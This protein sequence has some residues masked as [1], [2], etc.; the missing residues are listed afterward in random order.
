MEFE[1]ALLYEKRPF[2]FTA[3]FLLLIMAMAHAQSLPEDRK[4]QVKL[5]RDDM[6]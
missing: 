3:L 5:A 4:M 2:L 6:R 1:K